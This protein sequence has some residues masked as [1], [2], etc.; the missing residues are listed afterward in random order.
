VVLITTKSGKSGATR[1]ALKSSYSFDDVTQGY[2]LQRS[3]GQGDVGVSDTSCTA[4]DQYCTKYTWG[5]ALPSG[6]TTYDHFGEM[7]ETGHVFDNSLS[8]SGG[9]DR[10]TF[11]LSGGAMDHQ[12]FVVGP[13]DDYKRYTARLKAS[14]LIGEKFKIGGNLSYVDTRGS[15]IQRGNNVSGIMLGGL[16]TPPEF[17]NK[18]YLDPVT[19]LHRSYRFPNPTGASLDLGRGYDNPFFVMFKEPAT[20]GLSRVYGNV[21][22]NYEPWEWLKIQETAGADYYTD[23]RLEALPKTNSTNPPG[24]INRADF[25]NY[26]L[27]HNLT[28]V[29]S[30]TFSPNFAGTLTLGQNLNSTDFRQVYVSGFGLVSPEPL[31]ISNTIS[32]N[33]DDNETLVHRESYFGQATADLWDQLFLTAALRNDGFSTFAQ[34]S[35]RH[36]FPKAS[37]SWTFTKAAGNLGGKLDFGKV[38][39]AYGETGKEPTVYSTLDIFQVSSFFEY[40]GVGFLKTVYQGAPG[41]T[42]PLALGNNDLRPE[43]TKEYEGGIDLGAFKGFTDL[44]VSYYSSKT[45]DVIFPVPV[46]PSG[47][48][49]QQIANSAQLE[50]KGL[51]VQWNFHPLRNPTVAWDLGLQFGRNRNKV[52]SIAGAD[53]VPVGTNAIAATVA[54]VGFPVGSIEGK[55]FVRCG[56]GLTVTNAAG[57]DVDLDNTPTAS[58]GCQGAANGA[59]YIAEN[60]FPVIDQTLRILGS[61]QPDWS[62]SIRN[63]LTFLKRWELSALLDI[64]HGSQAY[65]GTRGALYVYGTHKDTDIRGQTFVFG[66]SVNGVKG[67]H[68]DKAVAGPGAGLPVVIDQDWFQGDGGSF[69]DNSADFVEDAGF[70]KL[71]EISIAYTADQPWVHNTL[72]LSSVDLRLSGRNLKTWTKFRGID[73]ETNLEGAGLVQG[74]DWFNNP[75]NRSFVITIGL[76]R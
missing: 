39:F 13:N 18:E 59:L 21:D 26:I 28:A 54:R 67:F 44:S 6:T 38:R 50:N 35:R 27:D 43:R 14:Q 7:F 40:G 65:D 32:Y 42:S 55:D 25:T 46:A 31:T 5:A 23:Q 20:S 19:G 76:N 47:G 30:H 57:V 58:G 15:F 1:Y 68:G 2:A 24:Q 16:R 17:N 70:V 22:L 56:R 8:V 69:G 48:Y 64:R 61:A 36:W 52:L 73:P 49:Q 63:T 34:N 62:G 12:G 53:E 29:A 45:V 4:P 74:V 37:A 66:P 60:G 11:F 33:P 75:Q 41:L 3:F 10:R 9:D 51:E 72:G 71:R